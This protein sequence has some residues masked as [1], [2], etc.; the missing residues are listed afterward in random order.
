MMVAVY[1]AAHP[2]LQLAGQVGYIIQEGFAVTLRTAGSNV[3]AGAAPLSPAVLESAWRM[4]VSLCTATG[5][6]CSAH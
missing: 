6:G 1:F 3:P 2:A 4:P 5:P